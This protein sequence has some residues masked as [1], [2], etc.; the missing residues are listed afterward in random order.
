M[1]PEITL[2]YDVDC[3]NVNAARTALGQAI[4]RARLDPGWIECERTTPGLPQRFLRFGSPTILVNGKDVADEPGAAAAC[5]RIYQTPDGLRGVPPVE[6]IVAAI[7]RAAVLKNVGG[8]LMTKTTASG[9]LGLAFV[10]ALGW[11]CCLPIAAGASGVALAGIAAAVGPWWPVLAAGS[12][13]LLGVAI[14]QAM[15]G[16]GGLNSDHCEARNH[17]GR[18]WL[19]VSVIGLFTIAL[20]TLPWWSAEITYRLIR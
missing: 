3:P 13:I 11:L 6:A 14:V 8:T 9:A 10:S 4:A 16:R 17:G 7:E 12:V 5:C 19:F 1:K 20:L 18:Q 15:R 2:V